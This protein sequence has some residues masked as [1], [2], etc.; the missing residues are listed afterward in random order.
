MLIFLYGPDSYR[1]YQAAKTITDKY[2]TKH[3]SGVNFFYLDALENGALS[4]FEDAV[5]TNSFFNETRLIVFKNIFSQSLLAGKVLDLIKRYELDSSKETVILAVDNKSQ[6]DITSSAKNLFSFLLDKSSPIKNFDFL[7]GAKLENWVKK[8]FEARNCSVG[9]QAVKKLINLVGNDSWALANEIEKLSNYKRGGVVQE[10]D[11]G[12]LV[13]ERTELNIF[14]F[15]DALAAKNQAKATELLYK[16]IAG[17][18]DPYYILT[19]IIYQFRNLLLVKDLAL[20]DLSSAEIAKK[21]GIHPFVVRKAVQSGS[22]FSVDEL[23]RLY[24]RLL[25]FDVA[26]KMGKI[27]LID[28]LYNFVLA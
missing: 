25:D 21:A 5:K 16:E 3:K 11:I 8:E 20:R 22:K 14:D 7:S 15:I 27:D 4:E 23:K 28:S 10:P 2:K 12:V 24:A 17:G 26:T 6:K 1:L 18:R 9:P 13:S 19:M